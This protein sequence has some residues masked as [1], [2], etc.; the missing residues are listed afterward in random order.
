[1]LLNQANLPVIQLLSFNAQLFQSVRSLS[2]TGIGSSSW[3]VD[4]VIGAYV[5]SRLTAETGGKWSVV[6]FTS[7][8]PSGRVL[9]SV[10]S[11]F[12]VGLE[13][14]KHKIDDFVDMV[15]HVSFLF[16]GL[17]LAHSR[18]QA[19]QD[20]MLWWEATSRSVEPGHIIR[21]WTVSLSLK[22]D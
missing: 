12:G 11:R 7:T 10:D 2:N 16:F 22:L 13:Y 6:D 3:R 15:L 4:D 19:Y 1:M 14:L 18:F 20:D 9:F 21:K 17:D 8:V 5:T